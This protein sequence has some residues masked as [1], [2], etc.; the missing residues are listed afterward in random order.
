MDQLIF[1]SVLDVE[2]LFDLLLI[3]NKKKGN[4]QSKLLEGQKNMIKE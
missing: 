1:E 4:K 2:A 3:R